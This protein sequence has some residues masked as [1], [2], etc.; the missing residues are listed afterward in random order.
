VNVVWNRG[1]LGCGFTTVR[2]LRAI[3]S[4]RHV[5]IAGSSSGSVLGSPKRAARIDENCGKDAS[6][7]T[8]S[9]G[10]GNQ[11]GNFDPLTNHHTE[12]RKSLLALQIVT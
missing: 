10:D 11:D 4:Y 7:Q 9:V 1:Y 2:A 6:F 5:A 12:N 3:L 8:D